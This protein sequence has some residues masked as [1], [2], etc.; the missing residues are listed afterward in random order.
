MLLNYTNTMFLQIKYPIP[1]YT[2]NAIHMYV[3]A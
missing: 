1:F 2:F 3:A